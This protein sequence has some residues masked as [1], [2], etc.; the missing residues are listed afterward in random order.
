MT[1][2]TMQ[3]LNCFDSAFIAMHNLRL[4]WTQS[5]R[6]GVLIMY[7]I[8]KIVLLKIHYLLTNIVL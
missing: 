5:M 4:S 8:C 1:K 6:N 3:L 7:Q 2:Q